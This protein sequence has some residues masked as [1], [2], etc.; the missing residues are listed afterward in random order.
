MNS[1][2]TVPIL[3]TGLFFLLAAPLGALLWRIVGRSAGD[4]G[5]ASCR[6]ARLW[7]LAAVIFSGLVLLRPHEHTFTGLDT[8]GYRLMARALAEGRALKGVDTALLELPRPVRSLVL[9]RPEHH[10]PTRDLSFRIDSMRTCKTH[11]F[12]YP[13]LP[14]AMIGLDFLVP[15]T[16]RDYLVPAAGVVFFCALLLTC[17]ARA[18]TVGFLI[19]ASFLLGSVYPVWFFRGTLPESVGAILVALSML[20][21]VAGEREERDS[22]YLEPFALGLSIA[23]HPLLVVLAVPSLGAVIFMTRDRRGRAVVLSL[24][25]FLAGVLPLV[26]MTRYITSPYGRF[27]LQ[28]PIIWWQKSMVMRAVT[29]LAALLPSHGTQVKTGLLDLWG[30]THFGFATMVLAA[31][32]CVAFTRG[33]GRSRIAATIVAATLPVFLYL[34]GVEQVGLWSERRL[35]PVVILAIA[36]SAPALSGFLRRLTDG[37]VMKRAGIALAAAGLLYAGLSNAVRWPA[38]YLV[39]QERGADAWVDRMKERFGKNT[40][41]FDYHAHSM[42]FAAG[43]TSRAFGFGSYAFEGIPRF[44]EWLA[45]TAKR[46]PVFLVSAYSGGWLEEGVVLEEVG[47]ETVTFERVRGKRGFP[48]VQSDKTLDLRIFKLSPEDG[49]P[50]AAMEKVFDGGEFGLR[51]PWG[52]RDIGIRTE[53][54]RRMPA[55]WSREGSGIVGPVPAPGGAVRVDMDA[56]AHR[57]NSSGNQVIRMVPPW[58]GEPL[59]LSVGGRYTRASGVLRRP[60]EL[61]EYRGVTGVYRLYAENPYNPKTE[62][63]KG[64]RKDLGV[65]IHKVVI[66]QAEN[67]PGGGEALGTTP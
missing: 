18:G 41:V 17:A 47:R 50:P 55:F 12:F 16:A 53:D 19:G 22:G 46:E 44:V 62:G 21:W 61:T 27:A 60:A 49:E 7:L 6:N 25:S 65:L 11:P 52:R 51:P 67:T 45:E 32:V 30:G 56:G 42:P 66:K 54:G 37:G 40:V 23:F 48:A 13:T 5:E 43:G 34:K 28:S 14:L 33:N 1:P 63:I 2:A 39:R 20:S 26:L 59:E 31:A 29:A 24:L 36:V 4:C 64:F 35:L 58:G 8:F 57:K 15:G 3:A 38:P 10:K 9:Y